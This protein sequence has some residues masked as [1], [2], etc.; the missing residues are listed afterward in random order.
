MLEYVLYNKFNTFAIIFSSITVIDLS[1]YFAL[2]YYRKVNEEEEED[3]E[4][5]EEMKLIGN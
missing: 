4:D 5:E 2:H 1:Y 3:E